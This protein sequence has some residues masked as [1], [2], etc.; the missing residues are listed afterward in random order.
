MSTGFFLRSGL[1]KCLSTLSARDWLP[2]PTALPARLALAAPS[3]IN[4]C[5][6]DWLQQTCV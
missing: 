3:T 6:G 1:M 2:I 5:A 4:G